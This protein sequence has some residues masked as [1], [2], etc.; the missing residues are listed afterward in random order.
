MLTHNENVKQA[1]RRTNVYEKEFHKCDYY[2][3]HLGTREQ[4]KRHFGEHLDPYAHSTTHKKQSGKRKNWNSE[5]YIYGIGKYK[6]L[7][8]T[9][10][11]SWEVK[12]KL[13]FLFST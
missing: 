3:T 9:K 2:L 13:E 5:G 12:M 7:D 11:N 8:L 1:Q 4:T 10:K 6:V